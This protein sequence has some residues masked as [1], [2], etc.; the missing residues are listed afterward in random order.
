[1]QIAAPG[2]LSLKSRLWRLLGQGATIQEAEAGKS[3]HNQQRQEKKEEQCSF[4]ERP[5]PPRS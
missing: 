1:L 2:R 3:D 4:H 5:F